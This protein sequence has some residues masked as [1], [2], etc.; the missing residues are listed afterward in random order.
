MG[1]SI[2]HKSLNRPGFQ[3]K[4][5]SV[6]L[7]AFPKESGQYLAT[8]GSGSGPQA[9]KRCATQQRRLDSLERA[10][11]LEMAARIREKP[12]AATP[13]VQE[14]GLR[15]FAALVKHL[16]V[17]DGQALSAIK[18]EALKEPIEKFDALLAEF[19]PLDLYVD[20]V[21]AA[22][23]PEVELQPGAGAT[24]FASSKDAQASNPLTANVETWVSSSWSSSASDS[25]KS[26]NWGV[27]LAPALR[28]SRVL[29]DFKEDH[30]PETFT[31][32]VDASTGSK[33]A[34]TVVKEVGSKDVAQ[35]CAVSLGDVGAAKGLRLSFAG[36]H[37]KNT[38]RCIGVE[39]VRVFHRAARTPSTSAADSL[40]Q[41]AQWLTSVAGA[42]STGA[43]GAAPVA[44][45]HDTSLGALAHLANAC[46][47]LRVV[48]QLANL[49]LK[50]PQRELPAAPAA[51]GRALLQ[52]VRAQ[53]SAER[54]RQSRREYMPPV[55]AGAGAGAAAGPAWGVI[56][57]AAFDPS[58]A[59]SGLTFSN[60]NRNVSSSGGQYCAV[61][62]GPFTEGKA[63]WTYKLVEDTTSQVRETDEEGLGGGGEAGAA[64]RLGSGSCAAFP[65]PSRACGHVSSITAWSFVTVKRTFIF[66][67]LVFCAQCSCFGACIKPVISQSYDSSEQLMMVR[68]FNG[69]CYQFGTTVGSGSDMKVNKGDEIRFELDFDV[70]GGSISV[71]ING[72]PKGVAFRGLAGKEIWCVC[73][74][75]GCVRVRSGAGAL[76]LCACVAAGRNAH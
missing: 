2:S 57:S 46:G 70:E 34:Y 28:I 63:A 44:A 4:V 30:L 19:S 54:V 56:E 25:S 73:S 39:R 49:L 69:Y 74:G 51:A 38:N 17:K 50:G 61:N 45:L 8:G 11:Y 13:A 29:V 64:G 7:S 23:D 66:L 26:A 32:D 15:A 58:A 65:V 67:A 5:S 9:T 71:A 62:V 72:T 55:V 6:P 36:A 20:L 1:I 24:A 48:L 41:L 14:A 3:R 76:Q 37:A 35:S 21:P 43:A 40:Q 75:C 68:A 59:S 42:S 22:G 33:E 60:E 53:A 18:A 12:G 52:A 10:L 47:S 16:S 31:V 27:K